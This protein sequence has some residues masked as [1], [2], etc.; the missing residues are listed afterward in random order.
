MNQ[1]D[2]ETFAWTLPCSLQAPGWAGYRS[3]HRPYNPHGLLRL[4]HDAIDFVG[5]VC[6]IGA[7]PGDPGLITVLGQR[8]LGE[9]DVVVY[10]TLANEALLEHVRPGAERIAVADRGTGNKLSQD[11]INALLLDRARQGMRVVRLKGGDPLLFGRGAEE[12]TFLGRHGVACRIVPGVTAGLAAPA[13]AGIPVTHRRHSS[14]VTLVT[15]HEDPTKPDS[16]VDMRALAALV[17]AGGTACFYMGAAKLESIARRLV[18]EGLAP[19]TSVAIVQAGTLPTQ[20]CVRTTLERAALDSGAAGLGPPAIIV[21]GSVAGIDDLA[22]QAFTRR[23]LF[24]QVVVNARTRRQASRLARKLRDLGALVLEAPTTEAHPVNDFSGLDRAVRDLAEF[25]WLVLHSVSVVVTLCDRIRDAGLDARHLHGIRVAA[26]GQ[27]TAA[28]LREGLAVRADEVLATLDAEPLARQLA[29]CGLRGKRMLLLRAG[30][31][32]PTVPRYLRD[33]GAQVTVLDVD[34]T[35]LASRLP[36][37]VLEALRQRTVDW[38]TFTSST[39]ARNMVKLL[40]DDLAQ[41]SHAKIAVI[42]P[43]TAEAISQAGFEPF[44]QPQG[45]GIDGLVDAMVAASRR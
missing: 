41:L 40:G 31:A 16:S 37:V 17:T 32:G 3:L 22:L 43:A 39:T 14:S 19:Q 29:E 24:G 44:V 2:E 8:L 13:A 36:D 7:G 45:G 5:S 1:Q 33:A 18:E 28:A 27:V 26:V 15:G 6:L 35:T 34:E 23:P 11:Q 21:V 42:G 9:A 25:D 20:R 38:I 10:D 4:T 12:A 30:P